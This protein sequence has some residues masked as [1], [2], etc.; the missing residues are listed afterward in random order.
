[1]RPF[2]AEQIADILNGVIVQAQIKQVVNT[3]MEYNKSVGIFLVKREVRKYTD[4]GMNF[5]WCETDM[6]M[7]AMGA[8]EIVR[9][10]RNAK[11]DSGRHD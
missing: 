5:L 3:S 11:G 2:T 6:S 4:M 9:E 7:M 10:A 8:R 1:M